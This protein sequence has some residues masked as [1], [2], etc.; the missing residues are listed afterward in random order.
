MYPE[1]VV[2][3][4]WSKVG[5]C[6]HGDGC[7]VCCWPWQGPLYDGY[8]RLF[9]PKAYRQG[10]SKTIRV[11]RLCLEIV[12]GDPLPPAL[13]ALHNCPDG[14]N[15]A[16]TNPTH[17]W[18]GTSLENI[19]DRVRKNRSARGDKSGARLHPERIPRGESHYFHLHPERRPRGDRH[20]LRLHPERRAIGVRN[21]SAKL[22]EHHIRTIR[23]RWQE[24]SGKRGMQ[25]Q[26]ARE[27]GVTHRL[28]ALIVRGELWAHVTD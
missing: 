27:F 8:G 5:K 10:K 15:R 2:K 6:I 11:N 16:C 4:F 3:R 17:L 20:G 25:S 1:S 24:A 7:E 21:G 22:T 28:I 18:R 9:L 26:L 12:T 23:R 14:D 13:Q 19:Q